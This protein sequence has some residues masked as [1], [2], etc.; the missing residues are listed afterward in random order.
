MER[1]MK[2]RITSLPL[3]L[4]LIFTLCGSS[5]Y[6]KTSSGDEVKPP[7]NAAT[8]ESA[9]KQRNEKI[10]TDVLKLVADAKAGKVTPTLRP[11]QPKNSNS[12]SSAAKIGIVVGITV[13]VIAIIVIAKDKGPGRVL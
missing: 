11:Q 7:D 2:N 5:T 4:L 6:A 9:S 10:R 12:L 3:V 1:I 8:K 13:A